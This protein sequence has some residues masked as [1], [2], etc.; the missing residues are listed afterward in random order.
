MKS[1]KIFLVTV[2]FSL[3]S[4]NVWANDFSAFEN[5]Q[6]QEVLEFRVQ[7]RMYASVDKAISEISKYHQQKLDSSI[8]SKLSDE[9]KITIDNMLVLA[10]YSYRYE[11][12]AKGSD[13][14]PFIMPQYEKVLAW[15]ENHPAADSNPYYILSAYD[16][17]NSTMQFLPQ[18]QSIKL[19][20]AEK[21]DY[22]ELRKKYPNLAFAKTSSG[23]WYYMAPA[24]GGGSKSLAKELFGDAVKTASSNYE[25]FYAN[26]YYSQILFEEK[27]TAEYEKYLSVAEKLLPENRYTPFIRKM[28][29][30]GFSL[31]YYSNNR[32][33]VDAK[34]N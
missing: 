20:L 25:T 19:G 13:L 18:S 30:A 2:L 9:A 15:N 10:E 16:I 29:A 6:I 23:L 31:L 24:I 26:I 11:K 5:E 4:V 22:D 28:N 3:F 34:L 32:E 8:Q 12:D 14:K 33:K 7:T 1:T 21:S 17:I 27:N